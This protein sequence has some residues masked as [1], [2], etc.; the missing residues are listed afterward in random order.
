MTFLKPDMEKFEC[1]GMAYDALRK[2]GSAPVVL[3]AANEVAVNLFLNG[4]ISFDA[5]PRLVRTALSSVPMKS[6][7]TLEDVFSTDTL[8]RKVVVEHSAQ[9]PHTVE[10]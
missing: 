2:G 3:N 8:A 7:L 6:N 1:L 4:E 10:A 9:H 5:I